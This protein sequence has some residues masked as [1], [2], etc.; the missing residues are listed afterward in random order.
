MQ[1]HFRRVLPALLLPFLVHSAH[2]A[3]TVYTTDSNTL[4]LYHLDEAASSTS[5]ASTG[6]LTSAAIAFDGNPA[7]NHASNAQATN[8]SI[9]GATAYSGYGSSANI[10]AADLGLGVDANNSGGF[11]MGVN[12]AAS[13]DAVTQGSLASGNGSFTVEAMINVSSITGANREIICTDNSLANNLRGFQF[14]ISTTGALEFNIV[15]TNTSTSTIAIPLT[16]ANGFVANEW[17]HAALSFDGG[18]NTATFYWTRVDPTFTTANALGTSTNE[19]TSAS[20]AGP[21][22]LGNEAR[23][24]VSAPNS[25]EGLLG[26]ID[27]VR[28]SNTARGANDF[29]FVPEPSSVLLGALGMLGLLRRRR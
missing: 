18:T 17:F 27:E 9:L 16:G 4:Y 12:G 29:I 20:L 6:S 13:P 15:G 1:T 19:M 14:R 8:S 10:T 5:A 7:A 2:A 28:I 24:A 3:L 11:Q 22:V 21:L 25:G 23:S 26:R